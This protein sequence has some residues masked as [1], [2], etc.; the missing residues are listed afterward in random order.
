[1][2]GVAFYLSETRHARE[3]E[4]R[5]AMVIRQAVQNNDVTAL[6]RAVRRGANPNAR[7][8]FGGAVLLD[9]REPEIAAALIRLGADVDVLDDRDGDTPLIRA[10]RMGNVALVRVLL[11]G[12]A[13]VHAE[14]TSGAT[15]LSE[16]VRG[17]HDEVAALLREAAANSNLERAR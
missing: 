15:A 3:P 2:L 11:A 16:A 13:S 17:G 5:Q 14:T 6:E 12:N 4:N 7:D 9:V 10:A 1:M 8:S